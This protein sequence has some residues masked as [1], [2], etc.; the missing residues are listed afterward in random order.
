MRTS[1]AARLGLSYWQAMLGSA[2]AVSGSC[3]GTSREQDVAYDSDG[4]LILS[5]AQ[6][7]A[8]KAVAR[9]RERASRC[10]LRIGSLSEKAPPDA[11]FTSP[12]LASPRRSSPHPIERLQSTRDVAQ[13]PDRGG[14]LSIHDPWQHSINVIVQRL[15]CAGTR[16]HHACGL[17]TRATCDELAAVRLEVAAFEL[18]GLQ[19][20]Y[21]FHRR[22]LPPSMCSTSFAE[23]RASA[24]KS[25]QDAVATFNSTW[26]RPRFSCSRPSRSPALGTQSPARLIAA[27]TFHPPF[28]PSPLPA[29]PYHPHP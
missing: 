28:P 22:G 18:H 21:T 20:C 1:L 27:P 14:F 23:W 7:A 5:E 16:P 3:S 4:D 11:T 25:H 2:A 12:T 17:S 29:Q 13:E 26:S 10:S 15:T 8:A 6:I 24:I 19:T 9:Q